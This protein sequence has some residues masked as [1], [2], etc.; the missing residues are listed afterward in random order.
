VFPL[1]V[2]TMIF[3]L[4]L[5]CAGDKPKISATLNQGAAL[6]GQLPANPLSWRIITSELNAADST[7]STLYGNDLATNYARTSAQR[8]YPAGSILALVTWTERE[9]DRWFGAKIPGQVRSVEFVFVGTSG[10]TPATSIKSTHPRYEKYEGSPL[11]LSV[12]HQV[13]RPGDRGTY[14]LSRRA[15][16][17][18]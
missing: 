6:V 9:D 8:D 17:M 16:V 5:G 4:G 18:P 1:V 14:L 10:D 15:A 11:K 7:M 12:S 3:A 13:F 2:V